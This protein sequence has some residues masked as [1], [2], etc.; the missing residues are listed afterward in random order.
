MD[1]QWIAG[2]LS[3]ELDMVGIGFASPVYPWNVDNTVGQ[4]NIC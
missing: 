2:T 3:T 4:V 1:G